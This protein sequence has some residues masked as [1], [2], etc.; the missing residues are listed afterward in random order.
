M[1]RAIKEICNTIDLVNTVHTGGYVTEINKELRRDYTCQ[2]LQA[3][4]DDYT[5][6]GSEGGEEIPSAE[7]VTF[8]GRCEEGV[9]VEVISGCGQAARQGLTCFVG[10]HESRADH[11][12]SRETDHLPNTRTPTSRTPLA[13]VCTQSRDYM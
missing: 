9:R 3:T 10:V 2:H 13:F 11:A 7:G 12:A 6:E 8:V 1:G 5:R 4:Q